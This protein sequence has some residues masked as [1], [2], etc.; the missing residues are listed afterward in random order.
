MF[1]NTVSGANALRSGMR[2]QSDQKYNNDNTQQF[3]ASNLS[4][5]GA[6]VMNQ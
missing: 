2:N 6:N 5:Y 1:N 3:K 4:Q